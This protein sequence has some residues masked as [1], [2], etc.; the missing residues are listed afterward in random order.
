VNVEACATKFF[1]RAILE[2]L[3]DEPVLALGAGAGSGIH[4]E[5]A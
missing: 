1:E 3:G 2:S 5:R 4:Y